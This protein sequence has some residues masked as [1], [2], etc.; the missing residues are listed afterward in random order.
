MDRHRDE[1]DFFLKIVVSLNRVLCADLESMV[2]RMKA[3][4]GNRLNYSVA[5]DRTE[6][7]R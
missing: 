5:F 2:G 6:F 1:A 3:H 7:D 4:F